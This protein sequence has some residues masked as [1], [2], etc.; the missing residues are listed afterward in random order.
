[1]P[2][3][4]VGLSK[5]VRLRV[6]GPWK[7]IPRSFV[8]RADYRKEYPTKTVEFTVENSRTPTGETI[9]MTPGKAKELSK[10]LAILADEA[11]KLYDRLQTKEKDAPKAVV[12]A[13]AG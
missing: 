8:V 11:D 6:G 9:V 7:L 13:R 1:M 12:S 4:I 2:I 3:H 10:A 5:V